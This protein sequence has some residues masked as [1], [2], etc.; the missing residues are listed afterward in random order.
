MRMRESGV[1]WWGGREKD[2]LRLRGRVSWL[3]I[4]RDRRG[5]D[6]IINGT[7]DRLATDR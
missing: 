2:R 1:R 5:S 4:R 6:L 7:R 3:L